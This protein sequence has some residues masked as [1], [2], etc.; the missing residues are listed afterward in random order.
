MATSG[1]ST[2]ITRATRSTSKASASAFPLTSCTAAYLCNASA[3]GASL[4]PA[5]NSIDS[6]SEQKHGSFDHLRR[7]LGSI[8]QGKTVHQPANDEGPQDNGP[9]RAAPAEEANPADHCRPNC[10]K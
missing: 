9:D 6:H 2:T 8:Q 4:G 5:H 1:D 3:A 7:C 10:L